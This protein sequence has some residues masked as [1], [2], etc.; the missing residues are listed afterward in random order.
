MYE[1][2]KEK[3]FGKKIFVH[4]NQNNKRMN[5]NQRMVEATIQAKSNQ[6]VVRLLILARNKKRKM[7]NDVIL[8]MWLY[9]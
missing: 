6:E 2:S 1:V 9:F 8:H 3:L 7:M 5:K 4:T